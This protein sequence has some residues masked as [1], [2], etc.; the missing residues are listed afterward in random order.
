MDQEKS[1]PA[2]R[3][4]AILIHRSGLH[5]I[6]GVLDP[7]QHEIRPFIEL[8]HEGEH[9]MAGLIKITPRM[10]VYRQTFTPEH[11]RFNE[12]NPNQQ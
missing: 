3:K 9:L 2:M 4:R 12:F 8:E 10:V 6:M 5:R 1:S 11:G 7:T